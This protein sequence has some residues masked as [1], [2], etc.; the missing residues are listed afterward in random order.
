MVVV[1]YSFTIHD[2]VLKKIK[3]RVDVES[4]Y[5]RYEDDVFVDGKIYRINEEVGKD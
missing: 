2:A 1:V 4:M 5:G 3:F